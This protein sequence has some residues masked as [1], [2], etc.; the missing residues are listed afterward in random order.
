LAL[1]SHW[2]KKRDWGRTFQLPAALDGVC[3]CS[4]LEGCQPAG[5]DTSS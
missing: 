3:S 2:A 4:Q 1:S 5:S